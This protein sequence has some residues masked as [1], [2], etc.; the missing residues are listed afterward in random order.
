VGLFRYL[1]QDRR[2]PESGI[3]FNESN[4]LDPAYD[5][6]T[7]CH[8]DAAATFAVLAS[9]FVFQLAIMQGLPLHDWLIK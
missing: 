6:M 3:V 8:V 4:Y 5:S 2:V 9:C 1:R 7:H